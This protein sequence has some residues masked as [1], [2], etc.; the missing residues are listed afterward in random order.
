MKGCGRKGSGLATNTKKPD[1]KKTCSSNKE[2]K[3]YSKNERQDGKSY[4]RL[5]RVQREEKRL[6][7]HLPSAYIS[8]EAVTAF[9]LGVV[10]MGHTQPISLGDRTKE[11]TLLFV[12]HSAYSVCVFP[13]LRLNSDPLSLVP[14]LGKAVHVYL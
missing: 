12:I 13:V 11:I 10:L 14:R 9:Q 7:P 5:V 2:H 1:F 8:S 4:Q 6:I 3:P